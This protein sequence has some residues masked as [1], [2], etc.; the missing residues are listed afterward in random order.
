[1]SAGVDEDEDDLRMV[2]LTDDQC[3]ELLHGTRER[4]TTGLFSLHE[5][6]ADDNLG[7]PDTLLGLW[8]DL[9]RLSSK[10]KAMLSLQGADL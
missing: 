2:A 10:V 4:V 8:V 1:M 5:R 7:H 6:Y 3:D 9:E